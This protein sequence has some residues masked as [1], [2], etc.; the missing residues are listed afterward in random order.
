MTSSTSSV[1]IGD[2]FNRVDGLDKVT[3]RARY[4]AEYAAPS[5]LYG[6][7]VSS[8]I[9]KGKISG[10]D[11]AAARAVSGVVEV[12]TH[13]NRPHLAWLDRSY[14]DEVSV[15][16]SPF[17]ALYDDEIAFSGQPIALV[18]A[19][20]LEGARAAAALVRVRYAPAPHNT[21]MNVALGE[22]FEPKKKRSTFIPPK[23]RGDAKAAYAAAPLRHS[24][25]YRL[26]AHFHN[27][28]E[29]HA[30][31][32]VWE[33]DG[34]ITVYDKT[35]GSQNVQGYLC[36][37][38][39]FSKDDVRVM[40][41]YVG[42]AFGSGLRPQYQVYL[43]TLAAKM[44]ER[45]VRV[46]LTRQQMFSHVHRPEAVQ[47]V[48]LATDDS[49]LLQAIVNDAT[50][51]TSRF[52]NYME[53]VC[54]WGLMNYRC[55][56]ASAEYTLAPIDTYT[57]GDMRAP[58]AATGMTLFEIAVDEMAALAGLDPLAFRMLNYSE[59]DAMNEKP[60]T[61]KS[62]RQA[63]DEGAARFGWS[64]R[65]MASR[66]MQEGSELIGWGMATGM[67]DAMFMKTSASARLMANGEL[68][69]ATAGSDIGT[70]T[71]TVMAQVASDT[72]GIPLDRIWARLGD[73]SLPASPV[74][75]GSWGAASS[76]AA[77]QLACQAIGKQLLDAADDMPG[78][79]LGKV[80]FEELAFL[81]GRMVV[82]S[83]PS[84]SVA[85]ADV[86][87]ASGKDVLEAEETA[88]PGIGDML[89]MAKK[90]RNTHSAIF[91]EVKVD[92]ALGVVRVTRIVCAVAAGRIINPKTARS[93][94]LGGVVMGLGMAL[95][96]EALTDHVLGRVMNHS[97]A[98]YHIPVNADVD[99]IEVIFVDEP[100]P[101]VTPLGVK[102]L[103]EIG[104]VG[105]A[106]A[107]ANAVFH[108]TG[109]RV[110]EL[111]VTIDKLL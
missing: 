66:S 88:K 32:V 82:K 46:V 20:T 94:I 43:A 1:A 4:A 19:D 72:L 105:T 79:P 5:L 13:E 37:V 59:I 14:T 98:E 18:V 109:K 3:G 89:S 68:E 60:Y 108:A 15:P 9:A 65:S 62:L 84:R 44:L 104:I 83:E 111:P 29:M 55:Q 26:P 100:D 85:I 48:Q 97:F 40:N 107:V 96:E 11:D 74:E 92:E 90:A 24:G 36:S 2:A 110:R 7:V 27:P 76:G 31:T 75:G 35:Q 80:K 73:S 91:A 17:R 39:G 33:G 61:S 87:A 78:R 101:E 56:N 50:T 81:D 28:M 77:V 71:Y 34:K 93:Q 99:E 47:S 8:D 12:I 23:A 54:N 21:D 58:G 52:E 41:P 22:K 38:F 25:E 57:P 106:A 63:Y 10:I 102:G 51:T 49:G 70:G 69:I 67:W 64:G 95:H 16:G 53:V 42:G 30:S 6:W 103:G 45:S 86:L